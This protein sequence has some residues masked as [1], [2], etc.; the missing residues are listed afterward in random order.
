MGKGWQQRVKQ[1]K[2]RKGL[3]YEERLKAWNLQSSPKQHLKEDTS[4]EALR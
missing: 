1:I 2:G 4:A 3:I